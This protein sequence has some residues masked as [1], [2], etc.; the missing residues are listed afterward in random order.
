MIDYSKIISEL[1]KELSEV[2]YRYSAEG[3]EPFYYE[4]EIGEAIAAVNKCADSLKETQQRHYTQ[5]LTRLSSFAKCFLTKQTR[6]RSI[7]EQG[8]TT[9]KV[10]QR[11]LR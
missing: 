8:F 4:R 11:F 1:G 6:Q 5:T 10:A 7:M 9:R 3:F 2:R